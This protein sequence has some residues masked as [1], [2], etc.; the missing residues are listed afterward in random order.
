MN[1]SVCRS[2]IEKVNTE[3]NVQAHHDRD[4]YRCKVVLQ[5]SL[6][7]LLK[8]VFRINIQEEKKEYKSQMYK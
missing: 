8:G 1:D 6:E 4:V 5:K 3:K 2:L 7:L